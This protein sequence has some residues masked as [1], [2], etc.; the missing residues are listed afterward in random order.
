MAV[1]CL[2]TVDLGRNAQVGRA[3]AGDYMAGI[4]SLASRLGVPAGEV[5]DHDDHAPLMAVL[6]LCRL[7]VGEL[8]GVLVRG[9]RCE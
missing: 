2:G 3:D 1:C 6:H 5:G 9:P 7:A 4:K 8:L